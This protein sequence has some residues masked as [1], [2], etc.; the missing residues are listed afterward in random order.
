MVFGFKSPVFKTMIHHLF[1]HV[2]RGHCDSIYS[3]YN[4]VQFSSHQKTAPNQNFRTGSSIKNF[5]TGELILGEQIS[6]QGS[7]ATCA[8]SVM[9][10]ILK[11]LGCLAMDWNR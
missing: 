8:T 6:C 7:R 1:I 3:G 11:Q 10:G 4:D 2:S 5:K 9:I